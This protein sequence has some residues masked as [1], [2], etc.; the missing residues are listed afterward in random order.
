MDGQGTKRRREIADNFNRLSRAHQCYRQTTRHG[1]AIE[2]SE[3]SLKS[4][5][6]TTC[7]AFKPPTEVFPWYELRENF[8]ECQLMANVPNGE[9]TLPNISTG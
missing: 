6:L 1:T 5:Y 9:E 4:L 8:S 3:R 7:I 2:Y